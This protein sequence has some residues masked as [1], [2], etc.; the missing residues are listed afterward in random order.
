MSDQAPTS[1][2]IEDPRPIAADAPYTFFLPS[3]EEVQ[4]IEVGD[5]VKL[6]FQ[7]E[8]DIEKWGG[9]RM[10]V[11]VTSIDGDELAGNLSN[12]P[13]EPQSPLKLNDQVS[14]SRPWAL[15][16]VWAEG[17]QGGS[18]VTTATMTWTSERRA[19][20]RS[21]SSSIATIAG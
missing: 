21:A 17:K 15:A 14:F 18:K 10:W 7:Y 20:L 8:G 12:E 4:A 3:V 13:D 1:Y 5:L 16:I 9:E 6:A 19:T 2:W 11:T